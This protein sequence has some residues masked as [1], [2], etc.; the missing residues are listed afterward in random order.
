MKFQEGVLSLLNN[1]IKKYPDKYILFDRFS[2]ITFNQLK[3]SIILNSQ[4]LT[5]LGIS[6]NDRVVLFLD[7]SIEYIEAYFSIIATGAIVV[8]LDIKTSK[9]LFFNILEDSGSKLIYTQPRFI[10]DL[11]RRV[12]STD[13]KY[14]NHNSKNFKNKKI[15]KFPKVKQDKI[16]SILYTTG[17]ESEPKGVALTHGNILETIRNISEFIPYNSNDHEV[18][19]LPLT[20]SFGLNHVLCN[21][22]ACGSVAIES[23]LLRVKSVFNLLKKKATG[24]PGSPNI[25]GIILERYFELFIEI[26]K[27]LKFIVIN[28]SPLPKEMA[29]KIMQ[30][31]P[32][33]KLYV[34]YGLTE[35]SRSTMILHS[36]DKDN[37]LESVGKAS[38][39]VAVSVLDDKG[40][41][42]KN[43]AKGEIVIKGGN[44]L[45]SYWGNKNKTDQSFFNGWFK[46]SDIGY[47]NNNGYLFII[48]RIKDQINIGGLKTSSDEIN[49]IYDKLDSILDFHAFSIKD[50]SKY[51][52]GEKIVAAVVVKNGGT[53]NKD[54]LVDF[55]RIHLEEY[56]VP[57]EYHFL[58][59]IPRS[60]TG[61]ILLS[62]L[63]KCVNMKN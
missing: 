31:L 8:P 33:T 51:A 14:Y 12:L 48:G 62:E 19:I 16:A 24:F 13:L 36:L 3:E 44:V 1:G 5:S 22:N 25:F 63:K 47:I 53:Q 58:N 23:G 49:N 11:K 61:K 40:N 15:I 42:Y 10:N 21:L 26:C 41:I 9:L 39:N 27:N 55:G 60:E 17:S 2:S 34:Y 46:T 50:D 38:P 59:K 45:A 32:N 35:A 28:S 6:S 56:K 30:S 54:S 57:K 52:S 43:N 37:L 29:I 7:N 20:H 18:V 4:N